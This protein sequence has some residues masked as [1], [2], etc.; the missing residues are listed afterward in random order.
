MLLDL[1]PCEVPSY[2]PTFDLTKQ[3]F[4]P[5]KNI[6]TVRELVKAKQDERIL[7]PR[8]EFVSR[9]EDSLM[10]WKPSGSSYRGTTM[11]IEGSHPY[12]LATSKVQDES[13]Q[14]KGGTYVM[15]SF[16]NWWKGSNPD[17]RGQNAKNADNVNE[18]THVNE[19][20]DQD[21]DFSLNY[22][23]DHEESI[24]TGTSRTIYGSVIPPK[25]PKPVTQVDHVPDDTVYQLYYGKPIPPDYLSGRYYDFTT[26]QQQRQQEYQRHQN[27][28]DPSEWLR[29]CFSSC[30][31][32]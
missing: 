5:A 20:D 3:K 29:N 9:M 19:N 8:S 11:A 13:N 17:G 10:R 6:P 12:Q 16:V 14:F 31:N 27:G 25:T 21:D 22:E 2:P 15:D 7:P 24:A 28:Q 4:L 32:M 30:T 1:R 26:L 23:P 18:E